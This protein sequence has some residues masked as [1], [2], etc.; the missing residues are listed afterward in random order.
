MAVARPEGGV[1]FLSSVAPNVGSESSE[2][3]IQSQVNG[4]ITGPYKV[5]RTPLLH[6]FVLMQRLGSEFSGDVVQ[7]IPSEFEGDDLFQR[8]L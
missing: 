2:K 5:V 8:S 3:S 7:G 1:K 4:Y 6:R